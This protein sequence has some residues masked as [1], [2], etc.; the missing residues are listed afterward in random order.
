MK[1][2]VRHTSKLQKKNGSQQRYIK[3]SYG[4]QLFKEN[5]FHCRT[6]FLGMCR[7]PNFIGWRRFC[8]LH[9]PTQSLLVSSVEDVTTASL[10]QKRMRNFHVPREAISASLQLDH[11]DQP[12]LSPRA[13]KKSN[14]H[15]SLYGA[16]GNRELIFSCHRRFCN[17]WG[18]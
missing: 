15:L 5:A 11:W 7:L 10:L 18:K 2:I 13:S 9:S 17:N 8:K 16:R 12:W 14:N 3:T 6:K 1:L 4:H